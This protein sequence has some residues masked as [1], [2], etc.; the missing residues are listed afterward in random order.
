MNRTHDAK[1]VLLSE[2]NTHKKHIQQVCSPKGC[3]V[4]ND[5]SVRFE[6]QKD[7]Y[8]RDRTIEDLNT[9][10]KN[11][12]NMLYDLNRKTPTMNLDRMPVG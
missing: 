2:Q 10:V 11:F 9:K 3:P 8:A 1:D 4:F 7:V 12:Q 6:L 5:Y